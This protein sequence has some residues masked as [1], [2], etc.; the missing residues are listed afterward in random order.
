MGLK[1]R[2][3]HKFKSKENPCGVS[4]L[5]FHP[6]QTGCSAPSLNQPPVVYKFSLT[7][8]RQA[9]ILGGGVEVGVH[10]FVLGFFFF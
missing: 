9:A 7:K 4:S 3:L 5:T 2:V 6:W 10:F 1:Y 8:R